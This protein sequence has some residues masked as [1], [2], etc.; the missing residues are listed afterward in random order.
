[1][2]IMTISGTPIELK[3]ADNWPGPEL[4]ERLHNQLCGQYLRDARSN[5]GIYLI[6]YRGEK[7]N[8]IHPESRKKL[9]FS[10]LIQSLKEEAGKIVSLDSKIEAIEIIDIDLTQRNRKS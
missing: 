1:M 10:T 7:K 6:V 4:F 2:R 8:W 3:I 9:N 5:N